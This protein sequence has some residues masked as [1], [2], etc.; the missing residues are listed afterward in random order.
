M[1]NRKLKVAVLMG[2]KSP[3]HEISL[4]S[5]AGV[6]KNLDRSKYEAW[7]VVVSK[8]GK[9]WS[10]EGETM[11]LGSALD[12]LKKKADL[13]F[14]AMHG[15]YGEDGIMQSILEYNGIPYTGSGVLASALGMDKVAS[16]R[17]WESQ[18]VK[19][20]PFYIVRRSKDVEDLVKKSG[21]PVVVK[22]SNQGS[23]VGVSI[24]LNKSQ[25]AKSFNNAVFPGGRVLVEPYIKGM[26]VTCGILGN[27]DPRALPPIEIVP[28]AD[29][30]YSYKA[31]YEEG[32]S[33]HIIPP[34]LSDESIRNIQEKAVRV[35]KALGCRGFGRVDG[36]WVGGKFVISEI[37]TIPGLTPT[38]LIP[39]EAKACGISYS[40][41]LDKI[42]GYAKS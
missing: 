13:V 29:T 18:G 21:Y 4:S 22:P 38:S 23:S 16:R 9:E 11:G 19:T 8:N 34:R 14:I 32:G 1:K 25:I 35:Y 12:I 33:K 24:V 39:E 7:G 2:G 3:E 26:E 17:I 6:L 31:K 27:E 10:I 41:L 30:F 36:F 5:G 42:I 15:S 37:N 20:T 28:T 40:E